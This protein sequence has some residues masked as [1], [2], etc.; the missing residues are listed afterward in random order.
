[1]SFLFI[2]ALLLAYFFLISSARGANWLI[3]LMETWLFLV[4]GWRISRM[5]K[6]R[7]MMT[8]P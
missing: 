3:L 2:S 5:R 6:T 8:T 7:M 1:M 4:I